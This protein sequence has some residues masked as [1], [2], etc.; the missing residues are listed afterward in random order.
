MHQ[1]STNG[2]E[3]VDVNI[4]KFKN[5][6]KSSMVNE[7]TENSSS[8]SFGGAGS[9]SETSIAAS[10]SDQK[11]ESQMWDHGA[12]LSMCDAIFASCH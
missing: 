1:I 9:G 2:N 12:S 10:F 6:G 5:S 3:D 8:S 7:I 4:T 11:V